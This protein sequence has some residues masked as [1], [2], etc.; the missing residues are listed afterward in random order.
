MGRRSGLTDAEAF[1]NVL[2]LL[3]NPGEYEEKLRDLQKAQDASNEAATSAN[4]EYEKLVGERVAIQMDR[5]SLITIKVETEAAIATLKA[6]E[7]T[8]QKVR[9]E[10]GNLEVDLLNREK[11]LEEVRT[12][13]EI[14]RQRVLADA[15]AREADLIV[16]EQ[17]LSGKEADYQNRIGRL[18]ALTVEV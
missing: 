9:E 16:R 3:S 18:K 13:F 4:Q 7:A 5:D 6:G 12:S 10:L 14:S 1:F 8:F 17:Q 2:S 15:D 11:R